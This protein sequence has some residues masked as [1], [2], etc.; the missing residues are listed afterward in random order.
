MSEVEAA[1]GSAW[2]TDTEHNVFLDSGDDLFPQEHVRN[3]FEDE[4]LDNFYFFLR[5]LPTTVAS[6]AYDCL[7]EKASFGIRVMDIS[8][9]R[10]QGLIKASNTIITNVIIIPQSPLLRLYHT[11]SFTKFIGDVLG[12]PKLYRLADPLVRRF[13]L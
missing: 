8:S 2:F 4:V 9:R 12:L 5:Q 1:K 3:R 7:D 10:N 11:E 6:L 13:S